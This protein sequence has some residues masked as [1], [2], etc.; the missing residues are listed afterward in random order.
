MGKVQQPLG[1]TKNQL[2]SREKTGGWGF[3]PI[4]LFEFMH[5]GA[6]KNDPYQIRWKL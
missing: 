2:A 6:S 1:G 4:K 3:A 5:I